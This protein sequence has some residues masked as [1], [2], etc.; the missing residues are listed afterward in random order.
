[1]RKRNGKRKMKKTDQWQPTIG[2]RSKRAVVD[3]PV[4]IIFASFIIEATIGQ[5]VLSTCAL[6]TII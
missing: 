2:I 5:N 6:A 3:K 1:M 4:L